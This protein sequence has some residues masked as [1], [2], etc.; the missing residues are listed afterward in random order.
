[1]KDKRISGYTDLPLSE[2]S[3]QSLRSV[4]KAFHLP[5]HFPMLASRKQTSV[6][7]IARTH[8]FGSKDGTL[9][10]HTAVTNPDFGESP[11][12]M[13]STHFENRNLTLG[14][15]FGCSDDQVERI[16][17]LINT[18]EDAMEHPFLMLG[19]S[20]QLQL[21]RI[22]TMVT[23]S[24]NDYLEILKKVEKEA[25]G[26]GKDRFSWATINEVRSTR[27][28]GKMV[29]EE[30][31]ETKRQLS[32]A[33]QSALDTLKTLP[34]QSSQASN[35]T[36]YLFSERFHDI[37]DRL[38][39]MGAKCRIIIEGI[40]Y[41]QIRN[42]LSRQE[43]QSSTENAKFATGISL[44]AMIYLPLTTMATIFAMPIFQWTND[45][46]NIR[47]RPVNNGSTSSN[48][49]PSSSNDETASPVVS[50][51]LWIYVGI[52]IGLSFITFLSFRLYM[53]I[54]DDDFSFK[55]TLSFSNFRGNIKKRWES[56]PFRS[57]DKGSASSHLSSPTDPSYV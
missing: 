47:Y 27:E 10:M 37:I 55:K 16:Q 35:E 57:G 32:K 39:S 41:I 38:D 3:W 30:V 43:S 18:W 36:T 9:W 28:K 48:S 50:G 31:Q 53:K 14:V 33:R 34:S 11:F 51:Y 12:A 15:M 46:R 22:V 56:I 24:Y 45:W 7:S 44:V 54:R 21:D 26:K 49:S 20:A 52:S 13:A 2:Q 29:E 17:N 42:E 23:T 19:I 8:Q 25:Q 1:F 4:V 6:I 40:S 5:G